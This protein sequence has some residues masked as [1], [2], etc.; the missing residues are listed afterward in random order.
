M[1]TFAVLDKTSH[2]SHARP[3]ATSPDRVTVEF[4]SI[5]I[6]E[7]VMLGRYDYSRAHAPLRAHR[8]Q[9]IFEV[10]ML[11]RGSQTYVADSTRYD[12]AGGDMFI[13]KPRE[14]H[15]TGG[16][17][18]NKGRLYWMEFRNAKTGQSF[19]GLTPKESDVLMR[20][21]MALTSRQFRNGH[22]LAATFERIL[23][24]RTDVDNP[25]QTANVKNLLL[26]LVLDIIAIAEH[27]LSRP[28]SVGVQR[29]VRHIEQ[30][31]GAIPGVPQL[32]QVASMSESYFKV[33]FKRETGMPPVEYAIWRRVEWAKHLLRTTDRP[34]TRIA[35][36]LGFATSQH[37]ATVFK[38]LGNLTPRSYRQRSRLPTRSQT[39]ITGAGAD[40]HPLLA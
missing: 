35:M 21:F 16:E 28:F 1:E 14:T 13:T 10:C 36:D 37:F 9:E 30:N 31:K 15:G 2:Q 39:P 5:G 12:L 22:F 7:I 23:L 4:A 26:R 29:A 33:V 34:I 32:A 6:P 11:E 24:A 40:F 25:L 17:P 3:V 27:H 20:R 8:H 18:E 38:R 19:L